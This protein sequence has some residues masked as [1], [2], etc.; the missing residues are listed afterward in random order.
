LAIARKKHI[1]L[2]PYLLVHL[3]LLA[4]GLR[5]GLLELAAVRAVR[6]RLRLLQRG[7]ILLLNLLELRP[8]EFAIAQQHDLRPRGEQRDDE[9]DQGDRKLFRQVPLRGVAHPPGQR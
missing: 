7:L 2:P 1:P 3:L 6:G 4:T 5:I 9:G 8:I